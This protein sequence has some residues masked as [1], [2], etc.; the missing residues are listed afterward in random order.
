[1]TKL[2]VGSWNVE[3]AGVSGGRAGAVASFIL[4]WF[5]IA[6]KADSAFR[7]NF[8][9]A[10]MDFSTD[11]AP[12]WGRPEIGGV[13][14]ERFSHASTMY[15]VPAFGGLVERRPDVRYQKAGPKTSIEKN[16]IAV[17]NK[18]VDVLFLNEV[19][20]DL[21]E[22]VKLL[23]HLAGGELVVGEWS[24]ESEMCSIV[25]VAR[26][27][28]CTFKSFPSGV[29]GVVGVIPNGLPVIL[30]GCHAKSGGGH[31]TQDD[32]A[33]LLAACTYARL[34]ADALCASHAFVV[35]DFN[36]VPP[37]PGYAPK[38]WRAA[39]EHS[40]HDERGTV[41]RWTAIHPGVGTHRSRTSSYAGPEAWSALDYAW[42]AAASSGL[43]CRITP[44]HPLADDLTK[45]NELHG[46]LSDHIPIAYELSFGASTTKMG[47]APWGFAW[48][49]GSPWDGFAFGRSST[50]IAVTDRQGDDGTLR[51]YETR[52]EGDCGIH[53]LFGERRGAQFECDE[54][55]MMARRDELAGY[56]QQLARDAHSGLG[57]RYIL[58]IAE[59][60]RLGDAA[61]LGALKGTTSTAVQ[62]AL[63]NQ[64]D[65]DESLPRLREALA[66]ELLRA[67]PRCARAVDY[68]ISD[69]ERA[70]APSR[71]DE[72][73]LASLRG[74]SGIGGKRTRYLECL[75][76]DREYAFTVVL[77]RAKPLVQEMREDFTLSSSA[78]EA[79]ETAFSR[80]AGTRALE[81]ALVMHAPGA[82]TA[83]A[84]ALRTRGYWLQ[85]I[86]V[87]LL[88]ARNGIAVRMYGAVSD[89][90]YVL[91]HALPVPQSTETR[92][93]LVTSTARNYNSPNHYEHAEL[94]QRS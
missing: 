65:I 40:F 62:E 28:R 14:G 11:L 30:F 77:N 75:K 31:D 6:V 57:A 18:G 58:V 76:E 35:G 91:R 16:D 10:P 23:L 17:A 88:A 27:G 55:V 8:S 22:L 24:D 85:D 45:H 87:L 36:T 39:R 20:G 73:V 92:A 4:D 41:I 82:F 29:R 44:V 42:H 56:V 48:G 1:M 51:A 81:R 59:R 63:T 60:I 2:R 34:E 54:K 79:A 47:Q 68:L 69:L 90:A 21:S 67:L 5:G 13:L 9:G 61:V 71:T 32:V 94:V 15:G 83:Y 33:R 66:V 53:A 49:K 93:I 3:R 72:R 25:A 84:S 12:L 80:A 89:D 64:K 46:A 70:A 43:E 78:V 50:D 7:S 37:Q 38:G 19:R 86:D 74:A 52:G 26:R